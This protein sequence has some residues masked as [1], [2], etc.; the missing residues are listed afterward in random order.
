[1]LA[2]V[3]AATILIKK[4]S[5]GTENGYKNVCVHEM[6]H[7][8]GFF[9]HSSR[10]SAVMYYATNGVYELTPREKN[11]LSQVYSLMR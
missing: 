5:N 3:N 10:T 1:M 2:E 4:Y 9:G 7:A 11:H 6:G 8:L